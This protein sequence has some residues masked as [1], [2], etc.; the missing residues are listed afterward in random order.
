[1][2]L[3]P[4]HW[5]FKLKDFWVFSS[6]QKGKKVFLVA[7]IDEEITRLQNGA[8]LGRPCILK[9]VLTGVVQLVEHSTV[10]HLLLPLDGDCARAELLEQFLIFGIKRNV[11]IPRGVSEP[12]HVVG[13]HHVGFWHPGGLHQPGLQT[14]EINVLEKHVISWV[15]AA[16]GKKTQHVF[17]D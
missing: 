8:Q 2:P 17:N 16:S 10:D 3:N 15:I 4:S 11:L 7:R 12:V 14:V 9:A 5:T 13:V 6:A 1:M